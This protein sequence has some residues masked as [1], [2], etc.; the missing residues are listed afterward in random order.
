VPAADCPEGTTALPA[1]SRSA[2][3]RCGGCSPGRYGHSDTAL[4][5]CLVI[6]HTKYT[7]WCDNDSNVYT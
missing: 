3:T 2:C 4:Y 6:L 7:G 5:I 1:S